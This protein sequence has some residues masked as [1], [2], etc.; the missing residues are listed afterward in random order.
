[1]LSQDCVGFVVEREGI[2]QALIRVVPSSP[3]NIAV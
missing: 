1:M 3:V 2:E